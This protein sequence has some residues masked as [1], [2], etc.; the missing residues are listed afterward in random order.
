MASMPFFA[1]AA[2]EREQ[3]ERD[4]HLSSIQRPLEV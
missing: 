1:A 2:Y 4:M 3:V